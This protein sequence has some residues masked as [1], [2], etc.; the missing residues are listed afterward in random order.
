[1]GVW[2]SAG[3]HMLSSPRSG[4]PKKG[5][6]RATPSGNRC[7]MSPSTKDALH[8]ALLSFVLILQL[9]HSIP[10]RQGSWTMTANGQQIDQA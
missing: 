2:R 5:R 7:P 10:D 1:V 8:Y 3:R 6:V 9:A 4:R